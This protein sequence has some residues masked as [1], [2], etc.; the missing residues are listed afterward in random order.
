MSYLPNE[1][2]SV[3]TNFLPNDD[4]TDLMVMS[5]NFNAFVT[6]RLKKIDQEMST[7]NQ[8]IKSFMPSPEP[9]PF[10]HDWIRQLNL[11]KF[12][13]IGSVAKKRMKEFFEDNAENDFLNWVRGVGDL[14]QISLEKC[15]KR[16]SLERFNNPTF[17]RVLCALIS[18]PKFR[19]EY[20]IPRDLAE[21]IK[22][23]CKNRLGISFGQTFRDVERISVFY[24][25]RRYSI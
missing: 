11:N 8:S 20:K 24:D 2:V 18:R 3:I 1:I 15:K 7:M 6:P 16:T 17:L 22:S 13:P 25:N 5:R 9:S 21:S 4:I 23:V 19:Q 12:E 10:D 14:G